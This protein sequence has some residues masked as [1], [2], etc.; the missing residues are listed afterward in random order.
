MTHDEVLKDIEETFGEISVA[1]RY[2]P[3]P[4]LEPLWTIWKNM[5]TK[6]TV[7]PNK[8]KE[9]ITLAVLSAIG[10]DVGPIYYRESAKLYGATDEEIQE[11]TMIARIA[12]S[13]LPYFRANII[14]KDQYKRDIE[15]IK[16]HIKTHNTLMEEDQIKPS[17]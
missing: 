5:Y 13:W 11:V 12:V 10:D 6:E 14:D 9:L 17:L 7:I 3:E 15:G 4:Y 2:V 1:W 16:Q 8:Y